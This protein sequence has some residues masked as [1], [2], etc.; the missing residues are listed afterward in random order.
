MQRPALLLAFAVFGLLFGIWQVALPDLT[1]ALELDE[2]RLGLALTVG[3]LAAFPAMWLAGRM[4][5]SRGAAPVML[6][7][8]AAMGAAFLALAM[9]P[10]YVVLIAVLLLFYAGSGAYDIAINAAALGVER[11]L[12]RHLMTQ[13]HASFSGGAMVGAIGT[14]LVLP[15]LP[16]NLV[17]L[18]VPVALAAVVAVVQRS[19]LPGPSRDLGSGRVALPFGAAVIG[20]AAIAV[21][22]TLSEG[23]LETWSAIYLRL[24][25]G[26]PETLGAAGVAL[27]HAAMLIGRVGGGRV[28]A[29]LNRRTTL[30]LA[31]TLTAVAMPIALAT[32]DP[33]IVLGGLFAVALGLS[34]LFPIAVSLA[35]SVAGDQSGR[36]ASLVITVGYAGFL[37]GPAVIGTVATLASLRV[38]LLVVA[39]GGLVTIATALGPLRRLRG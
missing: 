35:G 8:S 37:A 21:I 7:A 18:A 10:S 12:A 19:R 11:D 25:L 36:A 22:A 17:Y 39:L 9:V 31:G 4:V 3:F 34:V 32:D 28:V 2:A 13:L 27:F 24:A 29:H 20:L 38:A 6:V 33:W 26:L 16:F 23:A 30:V 14:G 1:L 15:L 5:D